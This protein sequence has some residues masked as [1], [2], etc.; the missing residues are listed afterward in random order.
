[1][2]NIILF[3]TVVFVFT[4]CY[5]QSGKRE[6]VTPSKTKS[7]TTTTD[8][9]YTYRV[10]I[11]GVTYVVESEFKYKPNDR[12]PVCFQGIPVLCNR[13]GADKIGLILE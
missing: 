12:V 7:L 11:E 13:P 8:T 9:L 6:T 5:S 2:K 3:I 4:A 10:E 1:M